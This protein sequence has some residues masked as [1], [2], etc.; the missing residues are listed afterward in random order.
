MSIK[1]PENK[2]DFRKSQ[3]NLRSWKTRKSQGKDHGKSWD[4]KSSK[5][6]EPCF[7][8]YV[9]STLHLK[10]LL[11][12]LFLFTLVAPQLASFILKQCQF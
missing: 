7:W 11:L 10:D 9:L 5:E 12:S 8:C 2:D 1:I 4:L 6:Y 3:L